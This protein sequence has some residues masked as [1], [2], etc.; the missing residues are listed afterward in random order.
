MMHLVLSV[1]AFALCFFGA[2][3]GLS[4]LDASGS[5]VDWYVAIKLPDGSEYA[6]FGDDGFK[7]QGALNKSANPI[8]N[9]LR[10]VYSQDATAV[11]SSIAYVL[12]NDEMPNGTTVTDR[13]HMKGALGFD[14]TSGFWLIHSTPRFPPFVRD[15]YTWPADEDDYGQH[16]LCITLGAETFNKVGSMLQIDHASIYDANVPESLRNVAPLLV[17]AID[18]DHVTTATANETNFN[19]YSGGGIFTGFAKNSQW[20]NALYEQL[21]EPYFKQG[22]QF[23]TWQNG[24]GGKMPSCC[25]PKCSYDSYNNVGIRLSSGQSWL[26]SQDHSKWGISLDSSNPIVCL[27]DINRQT[28]QAGRGGGTYCQSD[29]SLWKAFSSI[30]TGKVPC[31][32]S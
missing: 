5:A 11:S 6:L 28:S 26:E 19:S 23:E 10:Q 2:D 14:S 29:A 9:T 4:C 20:N 21:V 22:M 7:V 15:G 17:G 3:A 16:Y 25:T 1:A 18:G 31:S 30:I 13:A 27:G 12:Y 32:S 8:E 24:A